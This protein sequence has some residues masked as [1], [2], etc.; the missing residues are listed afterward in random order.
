MDVA[1]FYAKHHVELFRYLSR[2]TGDPDLAADATQE[3]FVKLLESPPREEV[4]ART[5][6][7]RVGVNAARHSARTRGRHLRLLE[8]SPARAPIADAP[9]TPDVALDREESRRTMQSVLAGLSERDR[10]VLL[11][12]EEG[13]THREIAE[14]AGTTTSSVGT[15]IARALDKLAVEL[16]LDEE[17]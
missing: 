14:A 8:Q 3:A 6:L 13:F 15:M 7:F 2:M 16:P 5:W 12:R 17:T 4:K 9:P 11:M 10:T 1:A